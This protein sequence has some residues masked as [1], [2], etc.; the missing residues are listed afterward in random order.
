[1]LQSEPS[2]NCGG[3][4]DGELGGL[5]AL[6]GGGFGFTFSTR[7]GRS[8]RDLGFIRLTGS[9]AAPTVWLT[10]TDV[11]DESQ[12]NLA[13]YGAAQ[14]LLGYRDPAGFKMAV[15]DFDGG[16]VDGPTTL[17]SSWAARDDFAS[18]DTGDVGWAAGAGSS[19]EVSVVRACAP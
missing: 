8:T 2:G 18:W 19:L 14:L 10:A 1:V 9:G 6:P 4:S 11:G 16:V 12:P 15:L 17:P 13:R 5:A 3:M 7:E